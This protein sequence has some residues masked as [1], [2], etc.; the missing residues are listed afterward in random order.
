MSKSGLDIRQRLAVARLP[1]MPHILIKLLD[2]CHGGNMGLGEDEGRSEDERLNDFAELI[3]KDAAVTMKI[4]GAANR[5]APTHQGSRPGI[6]QALLA[7]GM[8]T[9]K[10]L[11]IGESVSQVFGGFA[12]PDDTDL[13]GFW[14]HSYT[15]ALA[16]RKIALMTDYPHLEEAYLAGLL[17]DVGRLSLL[18]AAPSDY[19]PLLSHVDDSGLCV[20]EKQA[21]GITHAEA[22]AWLIGKFSLDSF[23]ADSVLYHHQPVAQLVAAHPLIRIVMLADIIASHGASEPAPEVAQLLFGLDAEAL[24]SISEDTGQRVKQTADLLKID[25]SGTEQAMAVP[26][27]SKRA[28]NDSTARD[29]L[30]LEVQQVM[31]AAETRRSFSGAEDELG[32]MSVVA[33]SAELQFG[34]GKVLLLM[35]DF[36]D[37]ACLRGVALGYSR[38]SFAEFSIPLR[39]GGAI[40]D[41]VQKR[42][43]AFLDA[44][45][46]G[47]NLAEDQ[48]FR[49][50]AAEHLVCLPL[51]FGQHG[52]GVMVASI[53]AFR[54]ADLRTK[55][56]SLRTFAFQAAAAIDAVRTKIMEAAR[57]A[58]KYRQASRWVVHEASNPLSIIK[59]YLAV[60][61]AKLSRKEP[62]QAEVTILSQEIDRVSQILRGL[63]DIQM[64]SSR[65]MLSI[66]QVVG[67][68]VR[69]LLV[70]GYV[71]PTISLEAQLQTEIAEIKVDS[72]ALKQIL[73]NLIKNS[74]EAI[75]ENGQILIAMPGH[76]NRD[77]RL[78]CALTVQDSGPGI[79]PTEMAK[80][81]S[82]MRSAKDGDHAGLGLS[83]VHGLVQGMGGIIM[84]R[85]NSAGTTF[86][87][88]LPVDA[89]MDG[90]KVNNLQNKKF[91]GDT[92]GRN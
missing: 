34:F 32:L 88:L 24:L 57:I 82:P 16:A 37:D 2:L 9:V 55:S 26:Y 5:S 38:H 42:Q 7:L 89:G 56:S 39:G 87:L 18:S 90:D 10:T 33:K 45:P 74:V 28:S 70:T 47:V 67:D 80:L 50:L 64:K 85:S 17:H 25:L 72:N 71:P 43:I 13:R 21:F 49:M 79:A 68:V 62:V 66:N 81:F 4:L 27:P 51:F 86:E 8:E 35:R 41:A 75:Q 59:N 3:A 60:L 36:E 77:G 48:L 46:D 92:Y 20:A 1:A 15:A 83:I 22:G 73:V 31:L 69:F 19:S 65:E 30:V 14:R 91:I 11:L 12:N 53:P 29:Q 54:L 63:S 6:S 23:L 44:E 84:C 40:S 78:Y 58:E 76:I 61:D 52:L